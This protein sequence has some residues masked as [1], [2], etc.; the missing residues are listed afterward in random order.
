MGVLGALRAIMECSEAAGC[1]GPVA[2]WCDNQSVVDTINQAPD[3]PSMLDA[4]R[5]CRHIFREIAD[6][7]DRWRDRGG[8]WSIRQNE[9]EVF[10]CLCC[11]VCCP[12][13]NGGGLLP[14]WVRGH[15]DRRPD[16]RPEASYTVAERLNL[17]ADGVAE[18]AGLNLEPSPPTTG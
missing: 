10:V 14:P 5:A 18:W 15:V 12:S 9:K 7:V 6:R 1:V 11:C 8:V 3:A 4:H 2:H 17:V 13:S 16:R